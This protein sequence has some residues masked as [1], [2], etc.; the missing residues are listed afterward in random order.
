MA[1][2]RSQI[3]WLLKGRSR[4]VALNSSSYEVLREP[5]SFLMPV[6]NEADLIEEVI[7][8]WIRDVVQHCPEG[9]EIRLEDCSTDATPGILKRLSEKY[10]FVHVDFVP[11]DGFYASMI[12]LYSSAKNPLVFFTDSDGQYV[13]EDFWKIAAFIND[14][15]MVHGVKAIRQDPWYRVVVSNASNILLRFL[16]RS[17]CRDAN[18]AFRLIHKR[19]LTSVVPDLRFM[20]MMPNAEVYLR[21]EAKGF[22]IKNLPV[23]HRIRTNGVSRGLP[24][25]RFIWACVEVFISVM[26]LRVEMWT[27][28][29]K[30]VHRA[31]LA[32]EQA[33]P[34]NQRD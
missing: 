8:E 28:K 6:F 9:S 17:K 1:S 11:R 27:N 12:R 20:K 15:D 16:F 34:A 13:A 22:K 3:G 23:T 30:I 25:G 26:K 31:D 21:T 33:G 18:S 5:V 19:V 2:D 32:E 24:L 29:A 14:Y 4:S 7:E 10:D